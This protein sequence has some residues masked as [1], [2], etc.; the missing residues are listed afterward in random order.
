LYIESADPF[1]KSGRLFPDGDAL[2]VDAGG[3]FSPAGG[4]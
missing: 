2:F 1:F 3:L 4:S